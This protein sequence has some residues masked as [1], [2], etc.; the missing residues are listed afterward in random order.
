MQP[1]CLLEMPQRQRWKIPQPQPFLGS[2]DEH[3]K[4]VTGKVWPF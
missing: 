4:Y 3:D 2:Q 1:D